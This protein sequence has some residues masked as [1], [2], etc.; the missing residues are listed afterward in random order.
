MG[1]RA[2]PGEISAKLR[3]VEVRLSQTSG[4]QT[5]SNRRTVH[6][7]L[8]SGSIASW[9]LNYEQFSNANCRFAVGGRQNPVSAASSCSHDAMARGS[10]FAVKCLNTFGSSTIL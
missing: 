10:N 7:E 5:R 9:Y 8:V 3:E 2:K 6:D 1:K 4:T